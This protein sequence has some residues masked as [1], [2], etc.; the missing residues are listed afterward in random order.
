M[1]FAFTVPLLVMLT[2]CTADL[3]LWM[4]TW[5]K[6]EQTASELGQII[7]RYQ[8]FYTGDFSGTFLPIAKNS[9][10]TSLTC[11]SSTPSPTNGMVVTGITNTGGV[12]TTAWQ[13]K[14]GSCVSSLYATGTGVNLPGGYV[15]PTG[16]SVILVELATTQS[17][18]ALSSALLKATSLTGVRTYAIAMPRYGS[19]PPLSNGTRPTS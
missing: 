5:L 10:G 3:V 9:A 19:L 11:A 15:P 6:M 18:Y 12:A 1:E 2:L 14:S 4:R 7:S 8:S 13:W 16:V 17:S